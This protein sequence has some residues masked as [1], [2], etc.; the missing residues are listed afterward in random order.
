[1]LTREE[2]R[3]IYD[4]GP[5]AVITVVEHLCVQIAE[6]TARVKAL[7]DRLA[8][9]SRN[10]STPP[11]SDGVAK[12]TR[13]LR[14]PSTQQAGGQPGHEGTTL[15]Q[16]AVPDQLLTHAPAQCGACGASLYDVAGQL[17]PERRQVFDLVWSKYSCGSQ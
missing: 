2:I 11:S 6:L 5:E 8:T 1:M 13:S 3:A 12:Q 7:E 16:V 15:T 9:T 17:D 14:Q 10:R 4:R